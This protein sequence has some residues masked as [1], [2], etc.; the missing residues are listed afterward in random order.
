MLVVDQM[1]NPDLSLF[2]R[3][4]YG[5]EPQEQCDEPFCL[6]K[7]RFS[8]PCLCAEVIGIAFRRIVGLPLAGRGTALHLPGPFIAAAA[9]LVFLTRKDSILTLNKKNK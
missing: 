5:L 7:V 9:V 8:P 3:V 6:Q 1:V 2:Q 4:L